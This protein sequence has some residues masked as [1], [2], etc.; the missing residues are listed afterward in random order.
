M[1]E[2]DLYPVVYISYAWGTETEA[3]I[4]K[5]ERKLQKN[6][7][8]TIRDKKDLK[9]K[10]LIKEFMTQLGQSR[11]IILMLNNEYFESENCM[12]ELLQIFKNKQFHD[13]IFPVVMGEL[14][15][16]K[17]K[18]RVRLI[19]YWEHQ[20]AG[21]ESE[22]R[23][24]KELSNIHGVSDDLDLYTEIRNTIASLTSM[25][26]DINTLS[27]EQH[28]QS[29]FDELLQR[30]REKIEHDHQVNHNDLQPGR[31]KTSMLKPAA[32]LLIGIAGIWLIFYFGQNTPDETKKAEINSGSEQLAEPDHADSI[33]EPAP[34]QPV[35]EPV[36]DTPGQ[37]EMV[38]YQVRIVVPSNMMNGTVLVDGQPADIVSRNLTFI[39][40]RVKQ[41]NGS[42][43][44]R[45]ENGNNSCNT[46]QL[47]SGNDH[48]VAMCD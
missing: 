28:L 17:A 8:S 41:K 26:S 35:A 40:V 12:F 27:L 15:I 13:R 43:N 42:H 48:T 29:D 25:I 30:V 37:K 33:L 45:V 24:L 16:Y 6:G 5:I 9:Y 7:I 46:D 10:G 44:F 19:K 38:T 2:Q 1:T 32:Y 20:A 3:V 22:I 23:E 34:E 11:Y 31:K 21:L 36:S 4:E 14:K 18:D 39:T 47:I